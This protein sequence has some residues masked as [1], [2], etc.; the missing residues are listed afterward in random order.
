[1][2][3]HCNIPV[4][5][6]RVHFVQGLLLRNDQLRTKIGHLHVHL[7]WQA[8]DRKQISNVIPSR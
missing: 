4:N 3:Y 7:Y 5:R 1:M 2:N 6:D 8:I